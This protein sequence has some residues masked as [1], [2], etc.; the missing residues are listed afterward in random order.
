MNSQGKI[1][2]VSSLGQ[3]G[4]LREQHIESLHITLLSV[5]I[6]LLDMSRWKKIFIKKVTDNLLLF[7]CVTVSVLYSTVFMYEDLK[8]AYVKI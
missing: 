4:S 6:D 2:I 5:L 8:H 3:I 1:N 7:S